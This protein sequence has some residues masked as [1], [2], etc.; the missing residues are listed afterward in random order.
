MVYLHNK[1]LKG[2]NTFFFCR[3]NLAELD[4]LL[5]EIASNP[6]P[7]A[8]DYQLRLRNLQVKIKLTLG[9]AKISS[10]NEDGGTLRDRLVNLQGKLE[11]VKNSIESSNAQI[12]EAKK[13]SDTAKTDVDNAKDV[14]ATA[15][16]SLRVSQIQTNVMSR[17]SGFALNLIHYENT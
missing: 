10:N 7:V 6:Q 9:D 8:N 11:D 15:R 1:Y 12:D 16:E 13:K 3:K 14:I 17:L 2:K 4:K 5:E